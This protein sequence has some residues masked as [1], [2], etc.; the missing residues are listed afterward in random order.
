VD[1]A[2]HLF[3]ADV[4]QIEVQDDRCDVVPRVDHVERFPPVAR[5]DSVESLALQGERGHLAHHRLVVHHQDRMSATL[6][7]GGLA[8]RTLIASRHDHRR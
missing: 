1:A 7:A 4:R 6:A 5:S 8:P 2:H 3:R